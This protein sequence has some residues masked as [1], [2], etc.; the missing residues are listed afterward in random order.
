MKDIPKLFFGGGFP[1]VL[2]SVMMKSN[3][4]NNNN[5]KKN[6]EEK[7]AVAQALGRPIH[8]W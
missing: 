2:F 4:F 6:Q 8:D 3:L 7:K 5:Q 1:L